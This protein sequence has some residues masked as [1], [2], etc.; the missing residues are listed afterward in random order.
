MQ[1]ELR[2]KGKDKTKQKS[3]IKRM[4]KMNI[5]TMCTLTMKG[6]ITCC[7]IFNYYYI[8]FRDKYTS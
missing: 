7:T 8:C 1:D 3:T 6:F 2:S 4:Q 5:I